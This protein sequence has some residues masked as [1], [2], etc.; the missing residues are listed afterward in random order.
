MHT[1][2]VYGLKLLILLS[3]LTDSTLLYYDTCTVHTLW[4][5][6][7]FWR[8][9]VQSGWF[10]ALLI[11]DTEEGVCL[12]LALSGLSLDYITD[13]KNRLSSMKATYMNIITFPVVPEKLWEAEKVGNGSLLPTAR[14]VPTDFEESVAMVATQSEIAFQ[15]KRIKTEKVNKYIYIICKIVNRGLNYHWYEQMSMLVLSLHCI[16]VLGLHKR[17]KHMAMS[18]CSLRT[19][20]F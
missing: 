11:L 3:I 17:V 12:L 15:N 7:I 2:A 1:Q 18:S 19:H 9:L 5:K 14:L 6:E 4:S 13:K 8:R 20:R 16:V 10:L